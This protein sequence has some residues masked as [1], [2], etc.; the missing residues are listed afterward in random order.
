MWAVFLLPKI[1]IRGDSENSSL[2]K[3]FP[4]PD[5]TITFTEAAQRNI[6][7]M[8]QR[9]IDVD[10]QYGDSPETTALLW[11]L[12]HALVGLIGLGGRISA[13]DD[14]SLL[15]DS[16]ITYGCVFHPKHVEGGG[17]DPLLGEW[18][19]HS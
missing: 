3:E 13:E 4:L 7:A 6:Q 16:F 17:R 9:V 19:I 5:K 15:G 11:S 14:L 1:T 2:T 18:S 10:R 12:V 8:R